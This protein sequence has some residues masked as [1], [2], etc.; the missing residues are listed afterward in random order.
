MVNM[1]KE[2][3]GTSERKNFKTNA[4]VSKDVDIQLLEDQLSMTGYTLAA[5]T[6]SNWVTRGP[7]KLITRSQTTGR[8][9]RKDLFI[10]ILEAM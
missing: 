3:L 8:S 10:L 2:T 5:P 9:G 7:H 4:A 1:L 6:F